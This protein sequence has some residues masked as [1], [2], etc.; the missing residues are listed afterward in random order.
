MF[1]GEIVAAGFEERAEP[2]IWYGSGY[3]RLM[4]ED[5]PPG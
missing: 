1:V 3:R 4:P 5:A 2:L